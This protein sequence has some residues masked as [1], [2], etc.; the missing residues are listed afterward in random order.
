MFAESPDNRQNSAW[1][2]P[3][4]MKTLRLERGLNETATIRKEDTFTARR[5]DVVTHACFRG[6]G[7]P[8]VLELQVQNAAELDDDMTTMMR[9]KRMTR[10]MM[11][12]PK[13]PAPKHQGL[14]QR[15]TRAKSKKQHLRK[16]QT[17]GPTQQRQNASKTTAKY[18]NKQRRTLQ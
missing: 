3:F 10:M 5:G 11:Y 14:V 17:T 16:I 7:V 1:L 8:C 2:R 4:Y 13:T 6:R 18:K 12:G 9:M 15:N